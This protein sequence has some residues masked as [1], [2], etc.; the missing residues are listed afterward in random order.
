MQKEIVIAGAVR[1]AIGKFGGS[2]ADTPPADLAAIVIK[3]ALARAG[4]PAD[5]VD[6]AYIG[7]VLQAAQGQNIARQAIIKAGLSESAPA[8]TINN[9]CGSGLKAVNMAAQA[10]I[11]GDADIMIAGGHRKHVRLR[12]C[13]PESPVRLPDGPRRIHRH[14]D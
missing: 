2:L 5:K 6:E 1:T 8:L 10:I 3:E 12:L 13:P 7:C 9:V 14:H 4:V 11:A